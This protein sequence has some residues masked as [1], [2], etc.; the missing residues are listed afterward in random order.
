L[1][2]VVIIGAGNIGHALAAL[3][4]ARPEL[5]VVIWG[6][7]WSDEAELTITA[8]GPE[9]I[10]A[11]GAVTAEKALE[12]AVE[13]ADVA[14]IAV[15]THC[16]RQVMS[17]VAAQLNRCS[18]VVAWEGTGR[19][20][21]HLIEL[22]IV[23]PVV[24]GLQRSPILCR[25]RSSGR[26]VELFGVRT[27]VVAAPTDPDH[28]TVARKLLSSLLPFRVAL[29]PDYDCVALSPSNPL[30]HPARVYACG[31]PGSD[32]PRA[33]T[34]FYADWDDAAS[35][36]LLALHAEVARL[37]DALHLPR[38][39]LRTLADAKPPLSPSELTAVHQAQACLAELLV[40][41]LQDADEVVVDRQ[42]RFCQEDI[43][44]G[45]GYI[46]EIADR[47]GVVMPTSRA[48]FDWYRVA[49]ME[50]H[51]SRASDVADHGLR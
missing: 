46:L 42:H 49:E 50:Q 4:G 44:E 43:G 19:F 20:R 33:G 51:R 17:Q 18:L 29:A 9:G 14:L 13:G 37:R 45:L 21:E 16:R 3:L 12:R 7:R 31:R 28:R 15:P 48:I 34:R 23:Q 5:R 27:E 25:V 30:I 1:T 10:Y 8:F 32:P 11:V 47:A 24:V 6:R 36:V 22:G 41:L 40:P 35:A 26:S 2:K 39:Y 38:K